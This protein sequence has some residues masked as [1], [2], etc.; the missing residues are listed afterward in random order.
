MGKRLLI[1]VVLLAAAISAYANA[2]V[3]PRVSITSQPAGATVIIDGRDRGTTPITLFDLAPGRHHVKYRLSGYI[4]VDRFFKTDE[5]PFIEKSEV[6]A[7]EKGLLLLKSEP[8]GANVMIDGVSFGQT[9]RLVTTLSAKDPHAVV[10][11]KAGYLDQ[12]ITVRFDGRKP[13]IRNETL[14]LASGT[15]EVRSDPAGAE[16]TVNGIARG[17]TPITVTDV[18]KGRAAV[19][20]TMEGFEDEVIPDISINAGDHQTV[21]RILRGLPGT[22]HL[23]S[24]PEGARFYVNGESHGKGPV[25]LTGLKPGDYNVRVELEGFGTESRTLSIANG[26][27]VREEFKL[28]NVMGRLEVRTNPVGAQLLLDGRPMG[29]TKSTD[30]SAEISDVFAIENLLTGEH[31]LVV[32]KDGFAESVRHPKIKSSKTSQANVRLRRIYIPDTEI[33]TSRGSYKGVLVT[34]KPDAVVLEV[35]PGITRSFSRDEIR[36]METLK[37]EK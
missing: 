4:E 22:L 34:V 6:L 1:L 2:P 25:T 27:S 24:V 23:A 15:I 13:Q 30:P 32:R 9:P 18:P 20:L 16:V 35:S 3:Q 11:R 29:I 10:F 19:K 14:V 36:R 31:T 33:V 17:R 8:T 26:E 5:G 21:S 28:S 7:E 12:K 37:A